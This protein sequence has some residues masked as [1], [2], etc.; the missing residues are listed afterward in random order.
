MIG[1]NCSLPTPPLALPT[2]SPASNISFNAIIALKRKK[3]NLTIP[4]SHLSI[5]SSFV[6]LFHTHA[7]LPYPLQHQCLLP[8]QLFPLFPS[9]FVTRIHFGLP[10][11]FLSHHLRLVSLLL[12]VLLLYPSTFHS[13]RHVFY[14]HV[15][16]LS[17][18]SSAY[19]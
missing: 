14:T 12:L 2:F 17:S 16:Y 1:G 15:L 3:D 18:K 9:K 5:V 13:I 7:L 19:S 4:P 11:T 10:S 6:Y 8:V